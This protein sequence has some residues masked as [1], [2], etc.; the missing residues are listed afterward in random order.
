MRPRQEGANVSG[1]AS[2]P[3]ASRCTRADAATRLR[4]AQ[5]Y[6]EVAEL[7]LG[8][9]TRDEYLNVAAGLAAL[10]GIAASDALCCL[11][12]GKR[13]R[14]ENH[15][16]AT[17]LLRTATPDG[18]ELAASLARLLDLKD[19]AHYGVMIVAASKGRDALRWAGRLVE[20]AREE[21]ER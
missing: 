18:A 3:R 14:G 17:T 12:L 19:A 20:R 6:L 16:D 8:E 2:R 13:H 9:P 1:A 5:A 11:R 15:R 7:V 4:T 21:F 10:A